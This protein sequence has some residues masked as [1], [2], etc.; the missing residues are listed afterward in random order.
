MNPREY[1]LKMINYSP[2]SERNKE[3]IT[4][5]LQQVFANCHKVLE[6]GSGSGQHVIH[7]AEQLPHITWQP[8]D[9]SFYFPG[10]AENL[11]IRASNI[12]EPYHLSLTT[13]PWIPGVRYDGLFSAN[14][15]HIMSWQQVIDFFQ[16]AGQQLAE[17]GVL[18]IYGPFKYQDEFTSPSNA[19]FDGWLKNRD[20]LSGVRDFAAVNTL[21]TD[22]GFSFVNDQPMPANNQL[23]VFKKTI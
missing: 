18:C 5:Q 12:L 10:L 9:L 16:H 14:T 3:P 19:D 17:D 21:A 1:G 2:S 6:I 22:N 11:S 23:L 15:L 20:P 13:V 8:A 7:F 4:A